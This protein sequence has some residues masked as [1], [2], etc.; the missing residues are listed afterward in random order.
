MEQ[1][2]DAQQVDEPAGKAPDAGLAYDE[3]MTDTD[4]ANIPPDSK[5]DPDASRESQ[6]RPEG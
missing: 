3:S 6:E 4:E 1:E 5:A 2:R